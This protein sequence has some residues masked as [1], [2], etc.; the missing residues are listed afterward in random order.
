MSVLELRKFS[1]APSGF[2]HSVF[3]LWLLADDDTM[4]CFPS[5]NPKTSVS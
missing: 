1:V 4:K 2:D 5:D 3:L